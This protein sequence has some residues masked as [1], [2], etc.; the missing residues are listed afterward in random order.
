MHFNRLFRT[1][2]IIG[3][4]TI[5]AL[6]ATEL[7]SSNANAADYD[8]SV[9]M[10][11]DENDKTGLPEDKIYYALTVE[12]TGDIKDKYYLNASA[13]PWPVS[14]SMQKT[15]DVLSDKT[16]DFTVTVT[17]PEW[18]NASDRQAITITATSVA[19]GESISA[20]I[21][22]YAECRQEFDLDLSGISGEP[23]SK[24]VDPG[25][26]TY[27]LLNITNNGNGE[28]DI[29]FSVDK[30][31]Y[32][33]WVVIFSSNSV[34]LEKR[35]DWTHINV[36]VTCPNSADA[37]KISLQIIGTSHGDPDEESDSQTVVP[38]VTYIPDFTV[39]PYGG[40]QKT[41]D[42]KESIVYGATIENKGN[43]EDTF[44]FSI[45]PG[46]WLADGW[47]ASLD[48]N[49]IT[50]SQDESVNL[51]S[52]LTVNA[53]D[54]LADDEAN[55]VVNV[56]SDDGALTKTL[57]T[58]TKINQ[59][60]DPAITIVGGT[61]KSVDPGDDVEFTVQVINNGNGE[62]EI[63]LSIMNDDQAPGSWG[64][65]SDSSVTLEAHANTTI[66]LTVT[67]PSDASYLDEGYTMRIFGTSEDGE[68]VT[69]I[70]TLKVNVNKDYDLSVTV[71][72]A[73]T[74]K[75]DPDG[76]VDFT[77]SIKNKGNAEDTILLTL[78]AEDA[79]WK[80]E[81]GSIV[82]SVDLNS[83]QSTDVTL[84]VNI[85]VDAAK[86][87]Y[88]IG[89]KGTSDEDPSPNPVNK[90]TEVIVS[91]NQTYDIIIT[92]PA[93][94]KSA[95]VNSQVDYELEI[96]NDG[97]GNDTLTLK[98][99]VYPDGWQVNFNQ[100]TLV[101]GAR[102]TAKV[103]MSVETP[104]SE[105][106]M[107]FFV[108]F[109]A[110]SQ[111]APESE[112]VVEIGSTITTINQT[113]EFDI[114][115]NPDYKS[116]Q[117]GDTIE[118][119]ISFMNKGTGDDNIKVEKGGDF[120]DTWTVSIASDVSIALGRTVFKTLTVSI[121]DET[122]K[123]EYHITLTGT[124]DDD[125]HDPPF[126]KG[127]SITINV[128]QEFNLTSSISVDTLS[129]DPF[130]QNLVHKVSFQ[131]TVNN[132][133]TGQDKFEF[134]SEFDATPVRK[135][136]WSVAFDPETIDLG[137]KEEGQVSAIITVPFKENIGTYALTIT[138][139]SQGDSS[140]TST[141]KVF[142]DVN[143]TYSLDLVTNFNS[144][145][146]TPSKIESELKDINFTI[147]VT[148]T[149]TGDDKFFLS[150]LGL[151]EGWF[152]NLAGNTGILTEGQSGDFTLNLRV[153]GREEPATYIVELIATSDGRPTVIENITLQI[154]VDELH[155]LEITTN[156]PIKKGDVN[157]FTHFDIVVTNKGTGFDT[158]TFDYR[159]VPTQLTVSFPDGTGTDPV[160]SN[161]QTTKVVRVF[162]EDKT[163]KAKFFFNITVTSDEDQSVEKIFMLTVDVNQSYEVKASLVASPAGNK[164]EPDSTVIYEWEV[165]NDGT[166][167]DGVTVEVPTK[168]GNDTNIPP[169]WKVTPI[170]YSFDLDAGETRVIDLEVEVDKD[171]QPETIF[172]VLY[173]TFHDGDEKIT[174][175]I[176]VIVN[177]TYD[178]STTLDTSILQIFPGFS[179]SAE[180]TVKNTG[181][182]VDYFK[183]ELSNVDGVIAIPDP[184]LTEPMVPG[185]TVI[186]IMDF[187]V[188]GGEEPRTELYW[189]NVTSQ[190]ASEDGIEVMDSSTIEVKIKETYGVFIGQS[191]ATFTVSP[192]HANQGTRSFSVTVTNE[193]SSDD[194]FNFDFRDDNNTNTYKK[195]ITL[196]NSIELGP[197]ASTSVQVQITVDP[198]KVDRL[199]EADGNLKDITFYVF[200]KGADD[201][202]VVV[203]GDTTKDFLCHV[204]IEEYRYAFFT[205][206]TP[207]SITMDV[208]DTAMVNATIKNEGNGIEQYSFIKDG[209][210]GMGQFTDWY[211]FNVSSVII[212]PLESVQ[213]SITVDPKSD[214]PVGQHD[215]EF[216]AE[217]ETIY[218]T[219][220]ES[221]RI[222]IEEKY[223]GSFVSATNRSSDPGKT[224]SIDVGVRNTGNAPHDF[225]MDLP[226]VPEGWDNPSWSGGNIKSIDGDSSG[227][228]TIEFD[229][230]DDFTKAK[231]GL[232]QFQLDGYY[233]DKGGSETKFA[234]SITLNLTVNTIYGVEVGADDYQDKAEP[235]DLVIYQIKIRN[236]G[237]TNET[238]QLSV[239]KA[240]ALEDAKPWTTIVGADPGNQI[241]IPTGET[242]YLDIQVAVPDFTDENDE[243]EKGLFGVK[244]KA[245][246]TNESTENGEQ[247][248]ELEVEEMFSVR[249]WA[250][251]PG[252]N[253]TLRENDNTEMSYTLNVRN[254]GNTNDDIVITVP[255]D[256]FSGEKSDWKAKFGTQT[257]K[258]VTLSSLAQQSV[259]LTLTIDKDTDPGEYTLQVRAESQGDTVVYV[260]STIYIN[261]SKATY[262]V[263]IEKFPTAIPKVN[264]SDESEIEFKFTLT[265]TGNQDDTYTVEVE[266]Q[267]GSGTYKGWIMEFEDKTDSRVDQLV[268]PTDL[269]GNTDL[270][271]SKNSRVDI[272]LYVIVAIDEEEDSYSEIAISATSDNDNSQVQY[273][274]FNLTVILPNIM[275]DDS[276]E[277]FNID[278]TTDIEEDDS[279]DINIRVFNDGGAETGEFY[280]F[281][282]NGK[283]ESPNELSGNYISYERVDNIPAHQYFEVSTEWDE[284]PG[285]ENDIYVYADK[286]IRSG[287]G[288]TLIDNS[289]SSDGKV[290]ES[291]E[292]DNTAT[293]SDTQQ[294]A[295]DLRPDLTIINIDYDDRE[296]DTT[297]TVTVTIA[298]EGSAVAE[299]SSAIV[300][301][302]I[303]GT[304][305]KG[306]VSNRINPELTEEIDIGDDI[307]MEFTWEIPDEKK[308]FTVKA[309]VDH[310]DDSNGKNDRL[311]VYVQTEEGGTTLDP[312]GNPLLIAVGVVALILIVVIVLMMGKMKQM[313]AGGM[314]PGGA[315][316]RKGGPKG[317][318]GARPPGKP[319]AK[320][321]PGARPPK[322]G[323]KPITPPRK[324]A[325]GP[326]RK[327]GARPPGKPGGPPGASMKPCPKCKTPIP[328]TSAKRPI[329]LICPKCGASGTLTK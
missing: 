148:N 203:E 106:A 39:L 3:I 171:A 64:S 139:T 301:L 190:E 269:K 304:S 114:T 253:E 296:M 6:I 270:Y 35:G 133:G 315:P 313:S 109:T 80:P 22:L 48:Y 42:P 83:D 283:R 145:Q 151:P 120:P 250:D 155:T 107:A 201:N 125:P 299:Q 87:D 24:A 194:I 122:L 82:S 282:Y 326:P 5:L 140:V 157:N 166:G 246:S 233:E 16:Y 260:Y 284:I 227:T 57:N 327:P 178:V 303:G 306:K 312:A 271:L 65:F 324:G 302:K 20:S 73:S 230:P 129:V 41:V 72:G 195:F 74:Q 131:F 156:E 108:N 311:T 68:N 187:D 25:E 130:P 76:T 308:N 262:G 93:S 239:L 118:F 184:T 287:E 99:T 225:K 165:T 200:S 55:I 206:V 197:G 263:Q 137:V 154:V 8:C 51:A 97:T 244:I 316:P 123:G 281:F 205:A 314:A 191:E 88:K 272:T 241:T 10:D 249:L 277:Y 9:Y 29:D 67:P 119:N 28:D 121:D 146:I 128:E 44:H 36:T 186:V 317:K 1:L 295:I 168:I 175:D 220:D 322:P 258:T 318:P 170:P 124:S 113:F 46:S 290:L 162:I 53:P 142:I 56:T 7:L 256:E 181:T 288:K 210:N 226:P 275:L 173:F 2:I 23:T 196:P 236:S 160:G 202:N 158:F 66:T 300:G 17:I 309:N 224:V 26:D 27:F 188:A 310:P 229:I 95:D 150:L 75:A 30:G 43:D 297:T 183:I 307:D 149:G 323:G 69:T 279:I 319:G 231:A 59:E 285:G 221:F 238:Y 21:T 98:V 261:L 254:L 31:D 176:T 292:N 237:N 248:F 161:N 242:R 91:V 273:L 174:R 251:I 267:L 102:E 4:V 259:T 38:D 34:T 177:Q 62:D 110:T 58:R 153:P 14:L 169:G 264:P 204:N 216:H 138:V 182:G 78:F 104:T 40:N 180:L 141:L 52:L 152:M 105:A 266:T 305:L 222:D 13:S 293:I 211:E 37:G 298:N 321:P 12:N 247:I 112:P 217:S 54:G 329:K 49:S 228:F 268:V 159:D 179:G 89:I 235:G 286:P 189:I 218:S 117:P 70:K 278:P 214:A 144:Q 47:N 63:T 223:G 215:L 127:V 143:Q 294:L 185:E 101:L 209:E 86:A 172:I 328:I 213:V 135:N 167:T 280:V 232:Y 134:S 199:A 198:Y 19:V 276:S 15:P 240:G 243:A 265:N 33:D 252:K 245:E 325:G 45:V 126:S 84:S 85:P 212:A 163:I 100:S 234:K 255:N 291:R 11:D 116:V 111:N 193:G 164:V 219:D 207:S 90:T 136:G 274:Y 103:T 18:A 192:T 94:Q 60:F 32:T 320:R 50:I 257:S 147:T 96:K 77:I 61:S 115:P 92:I 79:S 132:T 289:F 71:S 81:W 208:D